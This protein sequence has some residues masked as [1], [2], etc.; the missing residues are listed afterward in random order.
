MPVFISYKTKIEQVRKGVISIEGTI[1]PAMIQICIG[2][3]NGVVT[4]RNNYI[5][6][7][8]S[9]TAKIIFKGNA[10]FSEGVLISVDR[11]VLVLGN[12][13]VANKNFYISCNKRVELGDDITVGWNVN[14]LDSDNHTV[15]SP[16]GLKVGMRDI[17]IGNHVWIAAQV[18]ILKGSCVCDNSVIAY[19]SLVCKHFTKSNVLIGGAPA[20]IIEHNIN[21]DDCFNFDL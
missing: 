5:R 21:W 14:I 9:D 2:G 19:R 16:Q 20:N 3:T 8:L 15:I 17:K 10:I 1:S 18:D 7:G 13:F 6:I 4:E 12:N 11:G